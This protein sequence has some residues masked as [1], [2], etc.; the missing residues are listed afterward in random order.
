MDITISVLHVFSKLCS[1]IKLHAFLLLYPYLMK[2]SESKFVN[3][4][5]AAHKIIAVNPPRLK[6]TL[7]HPL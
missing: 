2:Y 3:E 5:Y 1:P 4:S 6:Q 7:E